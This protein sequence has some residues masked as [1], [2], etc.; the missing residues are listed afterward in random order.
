MVV[1]PKVLLRLPAASSS[2][3]DMGPG[4][5]FQPVVGEPGVKSDKVT[6]L[7]FCSGK[8]YYTIQKELHS[9]NIDNTAVIRLEVSWLQE[10]LLLFITLVFISMC[11][12]VV[13]VFLA[14]LSDRLI[15]ELKVYPWS[16]ARPAS[17]I[18]R[19][20]QCSKVPFSETAGPIKAKFYV[21]PPWVGGTK[22][23]LWHLGYMTKMAATPIYGKNLLL[24]NQLADFKETYVASGTPAHHSLFK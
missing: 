10:C 3:S 20:S 23:C 21:E 18:R 15:G 8:H 2:L 7:V 17:S 11:I 12:H 16:D 19:R 13:F 22:V 1:A 5:C 9:R 14:R 6:R 24:W 4:T